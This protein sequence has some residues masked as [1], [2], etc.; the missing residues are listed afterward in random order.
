[1]S[2]RRSPSDSRVISFG[3]FRLIAAQRLLLESEKPVQ[4]GSRAI[5]IL[6]ALVERAGESISKEELIACVWP[7]T[8]VD[9]SNLKVHVAA[10][11][12]A[13]GD[14]RNGNRYVINIPGRGYRFVAAISRL[15]FDETTRPSDPSIGRTSRL[16]APIFQVFGRA[17]N[18]ALLSHQLL[19]HRFVTIVG[20][21]GIGKTTVALATVQ[22]IGGSFRDGVEFVDLG[23]LS[24][25]SL[26]SSA[27]A[28][29]LGIGVYSD[30]TPRLVDYLRDKQ[31]LI[32][33]DSCEHIIE[34]AAALAENL[35]ESCES[36]IIL[37]TS[38]EPTQGAGERVYRLPPLESPPLSEGLAAAVAVTYPAVLLFVERV[39]ACIDGF[40]LRDADAPLVSDICRRLDGNALAIEMAA[41]RVS[42]FGVGG[43]NR[44]L[45]DR[46]RL[47]KGGRRTALP[48]H[49]ALR[50]TIDWSYDLLSEFERTILRRLA[51]FNR[52]FTM[53]AASTVAA[54]AEVMPSEA[55]D[56][57]GLLVNKS[58][59]SADLG[60]SIAVYR[61]LDTTRAYAMEKL[62]ESGEYDQQARLHAEYYLKVCESAG[63]ESSERNIPNWVTTYGGHLDDTRA[64]LDWAFSAGGDA[65]LGVQLTISAVPLWLNM[66]LMDECRKAV[67]RT[68]EKGIFCD[69]Q[70]MVLLAALGTSLYSIGPK[71]ETRSA[72]TAVLKIAEAL[73]DNDYRL[74]AL[75]GLWNVGVGG[76]RHRPALAVA[77]KFANLAAKT[78]DRVASLTGERLIGTSLFLLGEHSRGLQYFERM[79]SHSIADN[80]R[81]HVVRFKF[82]Q[83]VAA[84]AFAARILWITGFPDQALRTAE[85]SVAQAQALGHSVSICFALGSV[86]CPLTLSVGD[87]SAAKGNVAMLID[88]SEKHGLALWQAMGRRFKGNLD[89]KTGHPDSGLKL[90]FNAIDALH[91]SGFALYHTD[92]LAEYAE[93]LAA[94]G[95]ISQGLVIINRA[96]AQSRRNEERWCLPELLRIKGD[97]T[98]MS[99]DDGGQPE[100]EKLFLESLDWAR[101]QQ[102]LSWELRTSASLARMRRNQGRIGQAHDELAATYARFTEGFATADLEAARNLLAEL[103]EMSSQ[104]AN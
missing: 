27:L 35:L 45:D 25:P 52:V 102:A 43:V 81:S 61:L 26:V 96:L 47:L 95:Q 82:D 29:Q 55:P 91:E 22:E 84:G 64:A 59:L 30:P 75:W 21:G 53:E 100:A 1:M 71:A 58:L 7:D 28:T 40:Q 15:E 12:K 63:A 4:L 3:T 73:N 31:M 79:L 90:L 38:R 83:S 56:G 41:G 42:T 16:R 54:G 19:E 66:S 32:V 99:A 86:A 57:V 39:A 78:N 103:G 68:L 92:A 33:L 6:I 51:V 24:D 48:R 69:R 36:L 46:F 37:A 101:R 20:P 74:R 76:G 34:K 62:I 10:L 67:T 9:E 49:R 60:D 85:N 5:E 23:P 87:L 94:I 17:K 97:L 2:L 70:R 72:W 14:G 98:L 65:A 13:L 50:A 11:R 88:H 89:I 80:N 93:A 18:V 8:T 44:R 104:A 77:R